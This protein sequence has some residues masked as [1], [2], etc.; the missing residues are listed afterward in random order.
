MSH[1]LNHTHTCSLA[2]ALL[3]SRCLPLEI[4]LS[5]SRINLSRLCKNS[6]SYPQLPLRALCS[7]LTQ[8]D[9]GGLMNT[10]RMYHNTIIGSLLFQL[11]IV[12]LQARTCTDIRPYIHQ[13]T[14][15]VLKPTS[16]VHVARTYISSCV[17][18]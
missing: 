18:E 8:T 9:N 5:S 16:T 1:T 2:S 15:A 12:D 3:F 11:I 6:S 7:Y 13:R 17:C 4:L 14:I 10:F